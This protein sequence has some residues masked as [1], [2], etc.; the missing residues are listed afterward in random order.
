VLKGEP[1]PQLFSDE[2]WRVLQGGTAAGELASRR[3]DGTI[4]MRR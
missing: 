4:W 3:K 1:Q 2:M